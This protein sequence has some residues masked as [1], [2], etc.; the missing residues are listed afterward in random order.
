MPFT[1]INNKTIFYSVTPQTEDLNHPNTTLFIHG[2]G[3]SSCFYHT[4]IPRISSQS[5]CIAFDTPGSGLSSL[6][7]PPQSV[8]SIVEDAVALLD[9]LEGTVSNGKVWVVGHSMGGIISC[10]L[11]IQHSHRVKGLI[12]LGPIHPSTTLSE[13]F[14]KRIA[15]VLKDETEGLAD[16][17]P[18]NATGSKSTSTHRAFIRSLILGTSIAGY[19]SLCQVIAKAS[20]PEYARIDVPLLILAGAEDKTASYEGCKLIHDSAGV[21][22]GKKCINI[23][24]GVGHWHAIEAPQLLE[25]HILKFIVSIDQ[26][27][28]DMPDRVLK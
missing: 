12:L 1:T 14:I 13:V 15:T 16:T 10:E 11:A 25:E 28:G 4:I 17:I 5:T 21:T 3:S 23:L 24:P 18:F 20:V 19:L 7:G 8:N 27:D 9:T 6:D 26:M 2:L 22:A